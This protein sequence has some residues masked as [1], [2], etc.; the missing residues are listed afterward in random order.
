MS[1][2]R[3]KAKMAIVSKVY[4]DALIV[5]NS[6]PKDKMKKVTIHVFNGTEKN[7]TKSSAS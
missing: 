6:Q 1:S 3:S 2:D 5:C 7:L 4:G